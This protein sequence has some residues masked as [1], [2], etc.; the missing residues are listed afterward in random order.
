MKKIGIVIGIFVAVIFLG[1]LVIRVKK[2]DTDVTKNK[3]K[4]G[5]LLNGTKDDH[6]WS[7]SHYE[8][9][10]K[11]AQTLNLD[12]HYEE[13]VPLDDN[14]TRILEK[15]A[16]EGCQIVIANSFGYGEW[17]LE[18][19][20]KH[21]EIH[22]FHATGIENAPNLSTYFGRIYQIRYLCGIV[23]GLQ[24][25]TNEIG[26][27]AA[28]PISEVNRGINAF[29]RGVK[30][31]NPDA[32]VYVQWSNSWEEDETT[33]QA[34]RELIKDHNIDVFSM[35]SD[36][37]KVCD[38]AKEE[39]IWVIGYNMDNEELYQDIW[40]TSAVWNWESFY[41]PR[42]MECLQ[43]KFQSKHYWEGIRSGVVE[44]SPLSDNVNPKAVEIVEEEK[45][46]FKNGT[47]DVFYGP[48]TDRD[49]KLRIEEGE[50]MTDETML[51][52]FDWYV[53]GVILN[54]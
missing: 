18:A 52:A 5:V 28:F 21:P 53:E 32:N 13:S 31:V 43:G 34:A 37:L 54:E 7:Q 2:V 45:E 30:S 48:V 17:V 38:V 24:T 46:K 4:V 12:M 42:I 41:E 35:H 26:Y 3:T 44:L 16:E 33:E 27:V 25:Q 36:S 8:A 22:Y 39:G 14:C 1:I 51:D 9:L 23:A 11:T 6:S 20:K 15:F 29:T 40:L 19:S 10:E 47:F 50:S 49:G